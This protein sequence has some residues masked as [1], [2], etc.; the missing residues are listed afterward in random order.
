[1]DDIARFLSSRSIT[2]TL[3]STV[4]TALLLFLVVHQALLTVPDFIQVGAWVIVLVFGAGAFSFFFDPSKYRVA[5]SIILPPLVTSIALVL[6][7]VGYNQEK[8][9][10]ASLQ[11]QLH[12]TNQRLKE[13]RNALER[14]LDV[15][16]IKGVPWQIHQF[17]IGQGTICHIKILGINSLSVL[18]GYRPGLINL[19]LKDGA[20]LQVLLT[21]KDS[22]AFRERAIQE[23]TY[24]SK[25]SRRLEAE[26]NASEAILKDILN[27]LV[28][29]HKLNLDDLKDRFQI[30]YLP[31]IADRSLLFADHGVD[32]QTINNLGRIPTWCG[33]RFAAYNIYPRTAQE[34]GL[35]GS[36]HLVKEGTVDYEDNR[37]IFAELWEAKGVFLVKLEDL[38]SGM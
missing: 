8:R 16:V 5:L 2:L 22:S 33:N 7:G 21:N 17:L 25:R 6:I 35:A 37:A 14:Q 32:E 12:T 13:V 15:P 26:W 23:E 9:E 19:L 4:V 36:T 10:L 30:R 34:P 3:L 38:L 20:T 1:M 18:H 31:E 28:N 11:S 24:G 27:Q 29:R